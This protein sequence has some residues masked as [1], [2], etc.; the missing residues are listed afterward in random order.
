MGLWA[1]ISS[2]EAVQGRTAE[3]TFCSRMRR[4]MSW[5]Y[6]EPKS[7]MTMDLVAEFVAGSVAGG[8]GAGVVTVQ[9]GRDAEECKE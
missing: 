4:A 1:R 8:V 2:I 9:F 5:V 7:R 6:C 3:K